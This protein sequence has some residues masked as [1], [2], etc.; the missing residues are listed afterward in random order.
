MAQ[1][2][3]CVCGYFEE[4]KISICVISWFS[5]LQFFKNVENNIEKNCNGRY[6][7]DVDAMVIVDGG[8]QKLGE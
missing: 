2:R 8:R 5:C 3:F 4:C 1:C 6:V 7:C